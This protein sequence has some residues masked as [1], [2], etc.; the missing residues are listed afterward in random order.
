MNDFYAMRRLFSCSRLL[1]REFIQ[2]GDHWLERTNSVWSPAHR[3][4]S[5]LSL[6]SD[7]GTDS[8]L[9]IAPEKHKRFVACCETWFRICQY[10]AETILSG[11]M[12][13][14]YVKAKRCFVDVEIP[15]AFGK[16]CW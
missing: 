12:Y 15:T 13:F 2:V 11:N 8:E 16:L 5:F 3:W 7:D 6:L 9:G 1:S 14:C 10:E 4:F